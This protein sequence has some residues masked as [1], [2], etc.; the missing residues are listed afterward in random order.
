MVTCTFWESVLL[1]FSAIGREWHTGLVLPTFDIRHPTSPL[2]ISD[3]LQFTKLS[4]NKALRILPTRS[5]TAPGHHIPQRITIRT[6]ILARRSTTPHYGYPRVHVPVAAEKEISVWGSISRSFDFQHTYWQGQVTF[7]LYMMT[8]TEKFIFSKQPHASNPN[9]DP[10]FSQLVF[11]CPA[12]IFPRW[13]H[14]WSI[15]RTHRFFSLPLLQYD[16]HRTY[17]V[18]ST[19]PHVPHKSRLVLLQWPWR[20]ESSLRELEYCARGTC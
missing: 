14:D 10:Y 17:T 3:R 20:R 7:S 13:E 18:P 8:P 4:T 1:K 16:C 6:C 2:I 12:R 19:T 5:Y 9:R 15:L 11:R